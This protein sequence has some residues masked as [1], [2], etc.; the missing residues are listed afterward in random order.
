MAFA[1]ASKRKYLSV[2]QGH[3]PSVIHS[4]LSS[5]NSAF[6]KKIA[7]D[8]DYCCWEKNMGL[9]S[10]REYAI[11]DGISLG[12]AYRRV[13]QGRADAAKRDGRWVILTPT[14]GDAAELTGSRRE[15]TTTALGMPLTKA[16]EVR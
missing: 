12:T 16:R 10:I 8:D 11:Q 9:I 13:S 7:I 2:A 4:L 1:A 15:V 3:F 6:S 14:S 5:K